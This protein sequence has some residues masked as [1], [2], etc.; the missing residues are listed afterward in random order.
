MI[1]AKFMPGRKLD[2]ASRNKRELQAAS[3]Y[4]YKVLVISSD[5]SKT[6][7]DKYPGYTLIDDHQSTHVTYEMNK[8][9]RVVKI[10]WGYLVIIHYLRKVHADVMSCHDIDSLFLAWLAFLFKSK[11]P[12][13]IYDS[14]EF[15]IGR[16]ISRNK[17][18]RW[19]VLHLERFLI[20][21]CLFSIMVNDAIAD[22]VQRIHRLQTRPVVVR[23]TPFCWNIDEQKCLE[24]RKELLA[25][26]K[27]PQQTL[28]MYHG[29]VSRGRGIETLLE[30]VKRSENTC[31]LIL[32]NGEKKL[33]ERLGQQSV[34]LGI[35]DRVLFHPAVLM[36]YL[37]QYVGAADIG[38]V[39]IPAVSKSYYYMLPNK[40]FENIQAET[41]VICSDFPAISPIVKKYN[42]GLTC[43]PTDAETILACI[44]KLQ[45]DKELYL[46]FKDNMKKAKE[47]LCWEKE[48]QVLFNAFKYFIG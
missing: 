39:T 34:S 44:S 19:W 48:K 3:E 21:R 24:K 7:S 10:L 25:K 27:S 12:A 14:H 30:V 16:N 33:M 18:Q 9:V 2:F 37:W 15:E 45:N 26:M 43:N 41:P 29:G 28:L 4:G 36:E 1:Y 35:S 6:F 38:M 11:K 40:F 31:L 42:I 8:M 20:K 32:G 22:E 23:S 13:F 5:D 47:D 46:T 17:L